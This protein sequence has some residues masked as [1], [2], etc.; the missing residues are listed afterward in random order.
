MK[1][2]SSKTP[3]RTH[4]LILAASLALAS[5]GGNKVAENYATRMGTVLTTYRDQ[6][7]AKIIAEQQSYLD[8][9]KAHDA[10]RVERIRNLMLNEQDKRTLTTSDRLIRDKAAQPTR[11]VAWRSQI[12]AEIEQFAELD[13]QQ[14]E[15]IYAGELDA[16]KKSLEAMEDLSVEQ[17][18]LDRLKDTLGALAR[19]KSIIE[20]LKDAGEFGCEVNRN[21]QLLETTQALD[22]ISKQISSESDAAKKKLLE[23][24]KTLL[25][26]Q[27]KK[28]G[29]PC[30]VA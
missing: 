14:T 7:D 13:F 12:H 27:K 3:K 26:S 30:K 11:N 24:Q 22:D 4:Y 29:T 9:A 20:K 17:A 19:P 2:G 23:T 6:I 28:L 16:Y 21:F 25:E 5:C 1:R 10:A 15:Q 18:S 8:L